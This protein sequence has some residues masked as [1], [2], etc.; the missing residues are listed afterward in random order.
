[1]QSGV[2]SDLSFALGRGVPRETLGKLTAFSDLLREESDHQNLVSRATLDRLWER[3][4]V[5]SAQLV[6]LEETPGGSWV[7]VGS[8]AGLPGI[9]IA[10]LAEGP[11]T[12]IEPRRLRAHFLEQMVGELGLANRVEVVC[13]R[14]ERVTGQF[15]TI[16]ARAVAPLPKLLEMS[17][18]LSTRKTR[19]L[20]PKGRTAES[21][22]AA[23]R[24]NWHCKAEVR[25]SRTDPDSGILV[26]SGVRAKGKR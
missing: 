6:P 14:A 23:A 12:L 2:S 10:L 3:H 24:R 5:D 9:V 17:T 15:D 25:P 13:A 19:W 26:L 4:I 20:L 21:E 1:L 18:H 11:V 8:G 7:D 22:L 16:T